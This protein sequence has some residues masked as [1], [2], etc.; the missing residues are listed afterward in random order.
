[1]SRQKLWPFGQFGSGRVWRTK[2]Q[3]TK[4]GCC[5]SNLRGAGGAARR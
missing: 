3:E 4:I 1:M 2:T 5:A